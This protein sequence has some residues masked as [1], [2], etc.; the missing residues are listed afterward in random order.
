MTICDLRIVTSCYLPHPGAL[1]Q[2][3]GFTQ[4]RPFSA[5]M[6]LLVPQGR[7]ALGEPWVGPGGRGGLGVRALRQLSCRWAT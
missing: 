2:E 7:P 1:K 3:S 6:V 4:D 5:A